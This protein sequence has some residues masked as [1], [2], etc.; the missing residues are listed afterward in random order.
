MDRKGS[1]VF[2]SQM[3]VGAG[4]A[5]AL[6]V[7]RILAPKDCTLENGLRSMV[8]EARKRLR[9]GTREFVLDL[10]SVDRMNARLLATV[11]LLTREVRRAGGHLR[12]EGAGN[13]FRKWARTFHLLGPL[14]RR[15]VIEE[16]VVKPAVVA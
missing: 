3:N 11:L 1:K 13:E 10:S 8:R 6:E 15:G 9:M 4:N 5:M 2:I 14:E 16:D 7:V 12:L